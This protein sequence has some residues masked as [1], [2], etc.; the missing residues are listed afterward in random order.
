VRHLLLAVYGADLCSVASR[1]ADGRA[2][3]FKFVTT[4]TVEYSQL[5]I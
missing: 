2:G 3:S 4:N 1:R 5:D